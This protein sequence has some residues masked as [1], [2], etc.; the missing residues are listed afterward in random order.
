MEVVVSVLG[1]AGKVVIEV[2]AE[3]K[4]IT[5]MKVQVVVILRVA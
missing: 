5:A 1:K 3:L 2:W 4:E